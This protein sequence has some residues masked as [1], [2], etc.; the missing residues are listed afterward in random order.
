[1]SKAEIFKLQRAIAGDDLCLIY[2]ENRSIIGQYPT[3]KEDLYIL[4]DKLKVYFWGKHDDKTG[5]TE[6]IRYC[7]DRELR[8]IA[9]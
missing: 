9:W 8:N 6:F 2:N 5:K 1:M 4:H 7:D 3:T